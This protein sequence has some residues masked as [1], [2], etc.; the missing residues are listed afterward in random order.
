MWKRA[1]K[2]RKNTVILILIFLVGFTLM[3]VDNKRTQ[4]TYFFESFFLLVISP[5][6]SLIT[7]TLDSITGV[8]N[9]YFML[10]DAAHE[11][12]RLKLEMDALV[13][14]NKRL[15]E[16]V[17][18]L[19]RVSRLDV[20]SANS[21]EKALLATVIGRDATQWVKTVY[22]DK[23]TSDGVTENLAVVTNAGIVG[24]VIQ[25]S[26]NSSKV[27]LV[28]D[29]RSAVDSLF[30]E[31]RVPGVVVG[32]GSDLCEMKYV[33]MTAVV[34]AGDWVLSSG[35][36]GVFPKGLVVGRVLSVVKSKQGL[37]Q[38]IQLAPGADLA[39]LEEVLV[40]LP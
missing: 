31:S 39:R 23:G 24:H 20:Y 1:L 16:E 3:T 30:M 34:K 18:R 38:E 7:S 33:P 14:E 15:E 37:F 28:V 2:N 5:V 19:E 27:L 11:N 9:H 13:R 10:V 17:R 32:R 25:A 8:Y 29:R 4:G 6:Q 22:I 21:D 35:I 40:L 12:D 36:G 26:P